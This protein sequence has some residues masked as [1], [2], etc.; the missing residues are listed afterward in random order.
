MLLSSTAFFSL[1]A[2]KQPILQ[3]WFSAGNVLHFNVRCSGNR[4]DSSI[5]S[6]TLNKCTCPH[7]FLTHK[8]IFVNYQ[9]EMGRYFTDHFGKLVGLC[10]RGIYCRK[11]DVMSK[12]NPI[13]R[14]RLLF[15]ESLMQA[16]PVMLFFAK[17]K[18]LRCYCTWTSSNKTFG[19]HE[20]SPWPPFLAC[21]LFL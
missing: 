5:F 15:F 16:K 10:A 13:I 3:K 4:I 2:M 12:F 19:I 9:K 1:F 14:S 18:T 6:S 11:V 17:C 7:E 21:D 8:W 20:N